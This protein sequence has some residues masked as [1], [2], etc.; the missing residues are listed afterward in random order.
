[1]LD[2]VYLLTIFGSSTW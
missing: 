1:M 2:I